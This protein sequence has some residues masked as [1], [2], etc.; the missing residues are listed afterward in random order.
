LI[1]PGDVDAL[2]SAFKKIAAPEV[3]RRLSRASIDRFMLIN[4]YEGMVD[5]F[6]TLLYQE[7]KACS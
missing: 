1:K 2:V 6:E 3:Y 5:Q 4:D 7:L